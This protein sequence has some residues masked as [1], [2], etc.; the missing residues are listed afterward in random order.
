MTV[1]LDYCMGL[2]INPRISAAI[3][4]QLVAAIKEAQSK[5]PDVALVL[6]ERPAAS[7]RNSSASSSRSS[8]TASVAAFE[9]LVK[10]SG[11]EQK[12]V[13][14]ARALLEPALSGRI[15]AA[16]GHADMAALLTPAG[17]AFLMG[18]EAEYSKQVSLFGFAA[19]KSVPSQRGHAAHLKA[20][21]MH[22]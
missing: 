20:C 19:V 14:D 5:L 9:G 2:P 15:F 16:G 22:Q 21:H 4:P 7:A 11:S 17:K 6:L 1:K 3:R 12:A 13:L 10:I 18:L 8:R